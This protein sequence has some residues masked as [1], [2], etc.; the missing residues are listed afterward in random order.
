MSTRSLDKT[1]VLWER[2]RQVMPGG[3][4]ASA[5]MNGALGHPLFFERGQGAYLYDVDGHRCIDYCT[6]HGASLLGHG[7]PAIVAAVQ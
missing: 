5:R 1:R 2:A 7:H 3:V 4:N 6:S